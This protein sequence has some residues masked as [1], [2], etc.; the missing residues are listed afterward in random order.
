MVLDNSGFRAYC[1]S[2]FGGLNFLSV[3][4]VASAPINDDLTLLGMNV[5]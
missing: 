1:L 4:F 2:A 3:A 5:R